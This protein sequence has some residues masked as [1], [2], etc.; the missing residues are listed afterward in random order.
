VVLGKLLA[1]L[2]G[3]SQPKGP[4][5]SD[6]RAV[7]E[8]ARRHIDALVESASIAKESQNAATKVSRLAVADGTLSQLEALNREWPFLGLDAYLADARATLDQIR[9]SGNAADWARVAAE[10]E[11]GIQL[12]KSGAIDEALALY[13]G[14]AA[15]GA[16]TPHTYQRLAILYAK[17]KQWDDEMRAIE[18]ALKN[19]P[20]QRQG[21]FSTRLLKIAKKPRKP[22]P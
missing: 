5:E 6:R 21:W 20:P 3:P 15:L 10:N 18:L 9:E 14:L 8:M 13:E 4:S 17:R 19:L 2:F 7:S 22:A 12:E 16:D 1:S 11:K